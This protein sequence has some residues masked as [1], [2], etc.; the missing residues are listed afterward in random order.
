M[1]QG[2]GPFAGT[3]VEG[4]LLQAPLQIPSG[5]PLRLYAMAYVHAVDHILHQG[6]IQT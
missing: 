1:K 4:T 5:D 3:K 2:I 6:V